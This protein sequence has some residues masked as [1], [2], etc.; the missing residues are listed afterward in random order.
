LLSV[1]KNT[2]ECRIIS[3]WDPIVTQNYAIIFAL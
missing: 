1:S 2:I 3:C